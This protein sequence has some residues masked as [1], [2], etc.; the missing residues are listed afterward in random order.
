MCSF[1][2]NHD[3]LSSLQN[4]VQFGDDSN[5][6]ALL[7]QQEAHPCACS[8]VSMLVNMNSLSVD[9]LLYQLKGWLL[10]TW[11]HQQILSAVILFRLELWPGFV[12]SIL[13]YERSILLN[14]DISH[15]I[16]RTDTVYDYMNDVYNSGRANFYDAI[17]KGLVGEIV[18]T[19]CG[20]LLHVHLHCCVW[21]CNLTSVKKV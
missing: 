11:C 6:E 13:Q 18:L 16:L 5:W 8:Q 17:T 9:Q 2:Y 3:V 15:K 21:W 12:T 4:P 19:R 1:E 20:S 10:F 7:L 14:L